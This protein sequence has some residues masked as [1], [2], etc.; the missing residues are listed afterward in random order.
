MLPDIMW[1]KHIGVS[2]KYKTEKQN[3]AN[4]DRFCFIPIFI[5][6]GKTH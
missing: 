5:K 2:P 6:L 3:D 4:M 1:H